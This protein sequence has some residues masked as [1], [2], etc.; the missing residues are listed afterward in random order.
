MYGASAD[1]LVKEFDE[2]SRIAIHWGPPDR[3]T[4]LEYRFV[5]WQEH[6]FVQITES[7]F[8]G[9]ADQMVA[10]ALDS[11]GGFALVLAAAKALLEHNVVLTVVLDHMPPGLQL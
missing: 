10:Q 6:T 11:T 5:P 8:S 4:T 9:T 2:N 7:G 3:S 1:V